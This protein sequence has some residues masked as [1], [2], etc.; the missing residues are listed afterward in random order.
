MKIL[1][2][3][4]DFIWQS[5]LS[6]GCRVESLMRS[7]KSRRANPQPPQNAAPVFELFVGE[8][9][10]ACLH[11]PKREEMFWCSYRIEPVSEAADRILHDEATWNEVKF[12]V[13]AR[14]GRIPNA[15]TFTGGDFVTYCK[16]ET[17]RLSFRS[18]W[19]IDA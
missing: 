18:L 8:D 14:D 17:D 19:P 1:A 7:R 4:I 16:R 15:H 5:V 6:V 10:V 12:T 11:D 9:K 2:N 13:K 3:L